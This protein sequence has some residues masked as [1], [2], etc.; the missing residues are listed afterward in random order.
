MTVQP[1][2]NITIYT[3]VATS[4]EDMA[5][6]ALNEQQGI[7]I[8]LV[9]KLFPDCNVHV[10][11]DIGT[12]GIDRLDYE[13]KKGDCLSEMLHDIEDEKMD[14]IIVS[15]TDRLSRNVEDLEYIY[16]LAD[17]YDIPI[18]EA[19]SGIL[20]NC[21]PLLTRSIQNAIAKFEIDTTKA[22]IKQGMLSSQRKK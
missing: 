9:D 19:N 2:K 20:L 21:K 14:A 17:E 10:Y 5:R 22:R 8:E 18:Y 3:R 12:S 4:N 7:C 11:E 16:S 6:I 15:S 1:N 13:D